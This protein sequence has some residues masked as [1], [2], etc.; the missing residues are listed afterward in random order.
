MTSE[1]ESILSAYMDG[2]LDAEEQQWVESA[3]VSNPQLAEKLRS[4]T[5]IR[6][7]VAGLSRDAPVD[8]AP[9]VMA[10]IKGA[11]RPRSIAA[12]IPT[13]KSRSRRL[14]SPNGHL[15]AAAALL[16]FAALFLVQSILS[17][18]GDP[19]A[20]QSTAKTLASA[21]PAPP[22][23][24][25]S[26]TVATSNDR[27]RASLS[28]T[29]PL[30]SDATG[31]DVA[32]AGTH[33]VEL[34]ESTGSVTSR[35]LEE[36]RQYLDNP[37]LR[38]FFYVKNP[39]GGDSA[40]KVASIVEQTTHHGFFK[41]T[42][43]QGIVI[44]PAHPDRATVF[45]LV[46]NSKDVG[47]LEKQLTAS[48]PGLVAE[49]PVEPAIVT[50]LAD[51]GQVESFTAAPVGGVSISRNDLAL[52]AHDP[53]GADGAGQPPRQHA[54]SAQTRPTLEQEQSAPLPPQARS[55]G[56]DSRPE[57]SHR[58]DPSRDGHLP[59]GSLASVPDRARKQ[60]S[61]VGGA[62]SGRTAIAGVAK[63]AQAAKSAVASSVSAVGSS[64]SDDEIVVL[65]WVYEPGP[66]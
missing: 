11:S 50:Q 20:L 46:V 47:N 2:Q 9:Q 48:L 45:A 18:R 43:S 51:A 36:V 1:D 58:T 54:K 29:A 57:R 38:R 17:H 66:S 63:I 31:N 34:T 41:I 64:V 3:L 42:I 53:G 15:A 8:V 6:D 10:R 65:V 32:G 27:D 21:E 44:D 22:T 59:G 35:D 40:L 49:Q 28:D 16:G 62:E 60:E 37:N 24:S 23:S 7:L 39:R 52:L 13:W 55:V 5:G 12:G 4:L 56:S 26:D 25:V 30:R 19:G 14:F 61:G 33:P